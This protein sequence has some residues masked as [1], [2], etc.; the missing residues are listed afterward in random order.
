MILNNIDIGVMHT[1]TTKTWKQSQPSAS[2][3]RLL[4]HASNL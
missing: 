1:A 4:P 2:A 3:S